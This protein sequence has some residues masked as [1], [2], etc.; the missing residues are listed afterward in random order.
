MEPNQPLLEEARAAFERHAWE[1]AVGAFARAREAGRLGG[2]DAWRFALAAYLTGRED[3]FVRSLQEGHQA[4]LDADQPVPA[5]RCAFWLAFHLANRAE[6]AQA[7]GWLGR[8]ARLL[9]GLE[10]DCPERGYILLPV[11]QRQLMGGDPEAAGGTAAQVTAIAERFGDR[12]LLAF[13]LYLHGRALLRMDRVEDG[14]ALLDEAM[15][16]V[17]AGELS[18]I[19]TGILYCGVIGACREVWALRRA[20]EWT[21]ALSDWCE[22][23]P[24]MVAY[25]GECRVFRAELLQLRGEWGD[26][27]EEAHRATDRFARGS[28]PDASGFARYQAGEVHRLRGEFAAAE[29]AYREASRAGYEPQPGLAL[30]RLEQGD[31]D[32]AAAAIRRTLAEKPGRIRRTRLLPGHIEIMLATGDLDEARVACEELAGIAEVCRA[33]VLSAVVL[34]ARGAIELAA[35]NAMAALAPLRQ[36]LRDWQALD[37]PYEAA[38]VRVLLGRACRQVGDDEGATL[39]LQAARTIFERL[40]AAPDSARLDA[41]TRPAPRAGAHGLTPR[42][43]GVL[44]LVATGRTNRAIA[45]DLSISEKTVARHVANIF[46]K[47]GLSSRAAATAYAYEHHLLDPRA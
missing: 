13:G 20:R 7:T 8:A 17:P 32:A 18:P 38:R 22:R 16:S 25:T 30:L 35:G 33:D 2:D 36:A 27:I 1:H 12:D 31:R 5:A 37:A 44:A 14:L 47:L 10:A 41:L 45:V 29:A 24:D 43:R 9:E 34:K 3:A 4:F 46:N 21:A 26:A 11:G 19:V 40:G 6:M 42:E 23:E 28:L 15:V 39:E